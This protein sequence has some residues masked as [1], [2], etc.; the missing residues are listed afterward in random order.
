MALSDLSNV[1]KRDLGIR[2]EKR[3]DIEFTRARGWVKCAT[4]QRQW[5]ARA[6][7]ELPIDFPFFE[8]LWVFG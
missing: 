7:R 8:A 2:H 6:V 3:E 5:D 1:F 4:W